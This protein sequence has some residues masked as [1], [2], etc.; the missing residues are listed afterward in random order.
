MNLT[1]LPAKSGDRVYI[2]DRPLEA[3]I[4]REILLMFYKQ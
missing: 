2:T 1:I 4:G 3:L